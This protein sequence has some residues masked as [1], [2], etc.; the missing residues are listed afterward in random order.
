MLMLLR[1]LGLIAIKISFFA[2]RS[3]SMNNKQLTLIAKN[4]G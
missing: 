3:I 4:V 2:Q 1:M